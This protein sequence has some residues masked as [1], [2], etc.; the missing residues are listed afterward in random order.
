M[1]R[2]TRRSGLRA[3]VLL[4]GLA[5]Q[6][7]FAQAPVPGEVQ[8]SQ[9]TEAAAQSP[10]APVESRV[11]LGAGDLIEVSVYGVADLS[12]KARIGNSG[13]VYL[14]LI[15]YVDVSDLTVDEAQDLIEKR[16]SD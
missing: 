12:T 6:N 9:A 16:L 3:F 1:V 7:L 4:F 13:D 14:P 2:Q 5:G 11:K 10:S 15:D 8:P